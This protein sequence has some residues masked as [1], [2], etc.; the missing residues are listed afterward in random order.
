MATRK[1][2]AVSRRLEMHF[3]PLTPARLAAALLF[4]VSEPN[5]LADL[6]LR[7]R[8]PDQVAQD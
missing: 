8:D 1:T 4:P 6:V 7:P 3:G 5:R 2:G